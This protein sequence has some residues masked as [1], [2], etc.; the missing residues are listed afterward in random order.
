[1]RDRK[2]ERLIEKVRERERERAR[3]IER[4]RDR[5]RKINRDREK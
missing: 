2:R 3:L 1:M 5:E 4:V